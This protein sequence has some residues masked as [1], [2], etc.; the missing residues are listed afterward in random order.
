VARTSLRLWCDGGVGVEASDLL[1]RL[2][3]ERREGMGEVDLGSWMEEQTQQAAKIREFLQSF[4]RQRGCSRQC[5]GCWTAALDLA[6]LLHDELEDRD[7]KAVRITSLRNDIFEVREDVKRLV[8]SRRNASGSS[9][10][11]PA[12]SASANLHNERLRTRLRG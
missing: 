9:C 8:D 5:H 7:R 10:S 12:A 3:L 1:G 4:C 11:A 2:P 6:R